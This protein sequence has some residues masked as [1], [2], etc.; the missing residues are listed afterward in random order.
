MTDQP[1]L[2][3]DPAQ[4]EAPRHGSGLAIT[5]LVLG[6]LAFITC[7]LTAIPGLIC[8]IIALVKKRPGQGM[9]IAGV[10]CSGVSFLFLPIMAAIAI[11][12][13]LE[14][15]ITANEA[16]AAATL[17][18][19]IFTS[20]IQFQAAGTR[21][22][23]GDGR[24]E[25]GTLAEIEES[26][27]KGS[28]AT[29]PG[30]PYRFT[31]LVPTG[32]ASATADADKAAVAAKIP[33]VADLQEQTWI[34]VCWPAGP[35]HGRRRFLL[36]ADGRV[37]AESMTVAGQDMGEPSLDDILDGGRWERGIDTERWKPYMR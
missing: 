18:S 33:A 11:P 36:M 21:D 15:R 26:Y 2:E 3:A 5:S 9:A 19:G 17:K 37:H 32:P 7:G 22:T 13:L 6:I 25:Y 14:S 29:R 28:L 23:D 35:E 1:V 16:M 8:G 4:P 34:A 24:G 12:N 30:A 27:L 20:Q 31:I 10:V